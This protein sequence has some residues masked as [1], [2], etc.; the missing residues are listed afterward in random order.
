MHGRT[1][2]GWPAGWRR[3]CA[4][5]VGLGLRPD[6]GRGWGAAGHRAKQI[7]R[8]SFGKTEFLER[9]VFSRGAPRALLKKSKI[10]L[11][12]SIVFFSNFGVGLGRN[13]GKGVAR[14][15]LKKALA[16][17]VNISKGKPR[18]FYG[19]PAC[20]PPRPCRPAKPQT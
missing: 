14:P 9:G 16:Q 8:I 19:F 3:G 17:N 2:A 10:G 7:P 4:G 18:Y 1:A 15:P 5:W 6:P 11:L 13:F 20:R 12:K